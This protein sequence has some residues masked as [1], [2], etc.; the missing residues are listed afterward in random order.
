MFVVPSTNMVSTYDLSLPRPPPTCFSAAGLG[1]TSS[2]LGHMLTESLIFSRVANYGQHNILYLRS[3]QNFA[4]FLIFPLTKKNP[5]QYS[6]RDN[7]PAAAAAFTAFPRRRQ[8]PPA[9]AAASTRSPRSAPPSRQPPPAVAAASTRSTQSAPPSPPTGAA[10]PI[11]RSC[12]HA[13]SKYHR[14]F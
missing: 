14:R 5:Q 1:Y 13:F 3:I 12:R 10:L 6:L 7:P 8:P 9:V 2:F 11:V 4:L